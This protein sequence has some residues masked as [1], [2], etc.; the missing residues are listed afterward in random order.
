M[1]FTPFVI[2]LVG[3]KCVDQLQGSQCNVV[4]LNC[5]HSCNG[6]QAST[7]TSKDD[8]KITTPTLLTFPTTVSDMTT[9]RSEIST[10]ITT[11]EGKE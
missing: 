8:S 11:S 2:I 3:S 10:S 5:A 1:H 7:S 6:C 4:K 9:G